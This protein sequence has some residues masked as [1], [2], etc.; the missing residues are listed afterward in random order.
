MHGIDL[1]EDAAGTRTLGRRRSMSRTKSVGN[2]HQQPYDA[3]SYDFFH[4]IASAAANADICPRS[5]M[6]EGQSVLLAFRDS[7]GFHFRKQLFFQLRIHDNLFDDDLFR[8]HGSIS[9]A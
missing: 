4:H 6:W 7:R 2:D 3:C 9:Q 5:K 8:R 1:I